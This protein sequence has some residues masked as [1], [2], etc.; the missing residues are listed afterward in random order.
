MIR[1]R[2]YKPCDAGTI[3]S[4]CRDEKT[5]RLWGG[6]RFGS[7]PISEETMNRKYF[8]ENGDCTEKDNFYPVT[9]L[10]GGKPAGHFII[11]Y[12]DGDPSL[13]RFGW[14]IVDAERRGQR[15]GQRMLRQGL[16]YAFGILQARKVTIGVYETNLPALRCYLSAGFRRADPAKDSFEILDG[17]RTRI[18]E[19]E[20]GRDE[21]EKT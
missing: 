5:F 21:F 15:V 8:Q 18:L 14:V 17:R 11:R 10:E 12:L 3:V 6:P 4:W 9:A 19:L 13:L 2:P 1:I 16:R 7:F 20:I